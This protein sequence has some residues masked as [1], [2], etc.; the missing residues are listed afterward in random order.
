[1][2]SASALVPHCAYRRLLKARKPRK[3]EWDA[4]ADRGTTF[5][6]AVERWIREGVP[7]VLEDLEMQGW[8]DL[9][10]SQWAPPPGA[11]T[12]IAWGLSPDGDHVMV[13]EATPHVYES[14][15]GRPLLTAGRAD[16]CWG[17]VC[18][19][20]ID[21]KTGAWPVTPATEN[22]QVNAAG[23][24][25]AKRFGARAYVPGVYYVR[26]GYFDMGER[27]EI[28]SIQHAVRFDEVCAAARLDEKVPRP[29]EWC[30]SCWERRDCASALP[31]EAA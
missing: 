28:G 15:N 16:V 12:E 21:W 7:P 11:K 27:V 13:Q 10:A 25:L 2:I 29:G 1:M 19:Y 5:H 3:P 22:L 6:A 14:M 30:A 23:I 18:L 4:A 24:A 8:V 17:S 26:D 31:D 20:V 9:L